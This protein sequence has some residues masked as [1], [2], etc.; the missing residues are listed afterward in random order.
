MFDNLKIGK[1]MLLLSG[2]ILC[3]LLVVLGV[4]RYGLSNTVKS[5]Q[6]VAGGGQKDIEPPPA[7]GRNRGHYIQGLGKISEQVKILLDVEAL[8]EDEMLE[9]KLTEEKVSH[10]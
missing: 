5:G 9:V 8:I 4:G 7:T 10:V 3:L 6:E 2:T 1:K